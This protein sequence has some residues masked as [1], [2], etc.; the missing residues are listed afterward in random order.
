MSKH[1]LTHFF[2][3]FP[4]MYQDINVGKDIRPAFDRVSDEIVR[5]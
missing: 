1:Y 3:S 4:T 2:R 5:D